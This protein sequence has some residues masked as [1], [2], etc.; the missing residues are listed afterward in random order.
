[1]QSW[2]TG[3]FLLCLMCL[4]TSA[5]ADWKY[6][7]W[8]M[9]DEEL[10]TLASAIEPATPAEERAVGNPPLEAARYKAGHTA[11]GLEFTVYFLFDTANQLVAVSLQPRDP[12]AWLMANTLLEDSYGQP[13]VDDNEDQSGCTA[14]MRG[15]RAETEGNAVRLDALT[16]Y[17][18]YT[19]ETSRSSYRIRYESLG[20]ATAPGGFSTTGQR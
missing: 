13:V 9:S 20:D 3:T 14:I 18:H 12:N 2:R 19:P 11:A 10:A 6:T 7:R 5:N 15:W 4:G 1:M 17:D 16:C 8:G